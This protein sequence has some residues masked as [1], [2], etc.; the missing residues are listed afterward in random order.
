V[1]RVLLLDTNVASA[2]IHAHLAGL[3]LEVHVAGR[4]PSDFLAKSA[5]HYVDLDYSDVEATRLLVERLGVKHLVPGCNDVSYATCAAIHARRP[6]AGID[7]VEVVHI[8]GNKQAFRRYAALH[9]IPAPRQIEQT[10]ALAGR[11]VIVKP[12][13]AFSGRGVTAL[14]APSADEVAAAVALAKGFSASGACL[15]EEFVEGQLYSHSAFLGPDGVVA[16][17]IVEEYG[18][19]NP[20]TVD[21]SCVVADFDAGLLREIRAAIEQIARDLKLTSG[22]IHTQFIADGERFWIIEITRRCPGDLYSLLISLSTGFDYAANYVRPFIGEPFKDGAR[23]SEPIMR[24]TIALRRAQTYGALQFHRPVQVERFVP[25]SLAGDSVAAAPFARIGI[26]FARA[27]SPTALDEMM[28]ATVA[29]ELYS[30]ID[31][32]LAP[33]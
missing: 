2:P 18:S 17:F 4:N 19:I 13:D 22:L 1:D 27:E 31:H 7:P 26:L 11:P 16:D 10:D 15:I 24:H 21:T 33:Q 20:F 32:G 12:V 8:L 30:V 5:A 3:G 9:D 25:Q 23:R 14:K 6:F 29:G 28:A